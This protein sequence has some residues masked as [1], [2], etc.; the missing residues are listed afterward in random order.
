MAVFQGRAAAR[1]SPHPNDTITFVQD[2]G[3]LAWGCRSPRTPDYGS[4]IEP[5]PLMRMG[6]IYGKVCNQSYVLFGR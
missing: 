5:H 6:L 3:A 1:Q 4:Q 2:A